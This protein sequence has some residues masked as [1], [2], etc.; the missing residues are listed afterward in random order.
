[1]A[2]L[3]TNAEPPP[4]SVRMGA[5]WESRKRATPKSVN[6]HVRA[7]IIPPPIRPRGQARVAYAPAAKCAE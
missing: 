6:M 2:H 4:L 1:M 3:G 5:R 7:W